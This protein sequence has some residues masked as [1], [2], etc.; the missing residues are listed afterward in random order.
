MPTIFDETVW[1][2]SEASLNAAIRAE[3]AIAQHVLANGY[4]D[5][6]D[7][8]EE[9]VPYLLSVED[10]VATLNVK[11]PLTNSQSY[12]NRFFGITSYHDIREAMVYA[13]KDQSI[14]HIVLDIDSGGGSVAGLDDT[15]QLISLINKQVKPVTAYTSGSAYSAAYWL[16]ASA[17]DIRMSRGAG[18]GS[19]GVIAYHAERSKQLAEAGIT[20]TVVRAGKYKAL[21]NGVEPLSEEGEKQL[22]AQL[23]AAYDLFIDHVAENREKSAQYVDTVMAQG[24]EF[25]GQAAVDAGLADGI[26]TF[27]DLLS[28]IIKKSVDSTIDSPYTAGKQVRSLHASN[29]DNQMGKKTLTEQEIAALAAGASTQVDAENPKDVEASTEQDTE[30]GSDASA[31]ASA[32]T[33]HKETTTTSASND[34]LKFVSEQLKAA[35]ADLLKAHLELSKTQEKLADMN[36]VI[37]PLQEIAAKAVNNMR[38]ACRASALDMSAMNPAQIVAEHK[39]IV[40]TF[41]KQFPVGGVASVDEKTDST[42]KAPAMTAFELARTKATSFY[43]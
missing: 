33:E 41:A 11:G 28:E 26:A 20:V 22:Q 10:G 2:G 27:S 16:A 35:Q 37:E 15:G 18:M 3:E 19:I 13:A 36:A 25:F 23:N 40:A 30:Q 32:E 12:W 29:G 31:E 8:D 43:K 1:M 42:A 9:V 6:D 38:I 7:D 24:R 34:T 39:A 21:A 17:G 5:E 14:K 4:R